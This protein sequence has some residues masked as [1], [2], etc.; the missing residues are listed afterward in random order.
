V[1]FGDVDGDGKVDILVN[2]SGGP[3]ML[4]R[5][6]AP[7]GHHWLT[8]RLQGR[9]PNRFGIGARLSVTAGGR[10][11]IA[12]ARAGHSYA[13]TSDPRLHFGLGAA[14]RADRI[15]VRWPGGR[16]STLRDVPADRELILKETIR[17]GG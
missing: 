6:D 13:S 16:V 9:R 5:N 3:A 14:A 11:Q 4:L 2:N 12:E 17:Q 15:V 8:V 10:T 1:A 7:P